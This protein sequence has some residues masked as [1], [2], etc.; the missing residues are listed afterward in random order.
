[1]RTRERPGPTTE[2]S[3]LRAALVAFVRA[4]PRAAAEPPDLG[5]WENEGG[6]A[7]TRAAQE[8]AARTL[9][10]SERWAWSGDPA[11]FGEVDAALRAYARQHRR[12]RV[13][14][15]PTLASAR[16][17]VDEYLAPYLS[18][19]GLAAVQRDVARACLEAYFTR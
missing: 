15:T 3:A 6:P 12:A 2:A 10:A 19:D 9:A 13:G 17:M 18:H 5:R 7:D 4:H 8:A 14:L 1:M 11:S 16:A